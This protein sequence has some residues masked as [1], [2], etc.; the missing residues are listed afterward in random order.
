M[1]QAKVG[2]VLVTALDPFFGAPP[3]PASRS[4]FLADHACIRRRPRSIAGNWITSGG[5]RPSVAGPQ[6]FLAEARAASSV[7][8]DA[9][10]KR[11]FPLP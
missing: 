7:L 8:E 6:R 5:E 4:A 1:A 11:S 10:H 2:R 3:L 9:A